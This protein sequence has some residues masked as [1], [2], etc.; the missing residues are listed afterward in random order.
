VLFQE[1]GLWE[2]TPLKRDRDEY[3][4]YDVTDI[5]YFLKKYSYSLRRSSFV[6]LS[7]PRSALGNR[8]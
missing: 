1:F 5:I 8:V 6:K 3:D 4:K 2:Y 7:F